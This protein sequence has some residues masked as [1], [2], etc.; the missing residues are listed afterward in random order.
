MKRMAVNPYL[1][2][3]EY[4]PDGEPHVFDGRL[5]IYGSHDKAHGTGYC[6]EDYVVWSAPVSDLSDWR[7]D[8]ISFRK[9]Q[10]SHNGCLKELWAPDV[11]KGTDGRYYLYYARAFVPEIGVAVSDSPAGPFEFYGFLQHENGEI[12]KE[13]LPFDPAVLYE[14]EDHIWLYSGFG[15]DPVPGMTMDMLQQMP[16]FSNLSKQELEG[17]MEHMDVMSNP[18]KSCSCLRLASDM[19]TVLKSSPVIPVHCN[20]AG[21]SFEEHPFLEASSIRKM[22]DTYYLVYSSIQGNEL[23]YATS[24]YPDRDFIFGGV[25]IS[26]GDLGYEGN[27]KRRAYTANNHGGMVEINGQWYIFY[28]RHTN[29][30][31]FSRQGCAEPITILSD[32]SIPQVEMTSCGLNGGALN[33]DQPYSAHICCNIMGADG[34][35]DID[36]YENMKMDNPYITE[37][38]TG[39]SKNQYVANLQ[40]GSVCGVKYLNFQGE[41]SVE[42][43]LRG[44]GQLALLLDH[45]DA[46]TFAAADVDSGEWKRYTM[47][48]EPVCGVHAIYFKCVS[49][50]GAVDFS[51]FC[52]KKEIDFKKKRLDCTKEAEHLVSLMSLEEKARMM[53]ATFDV[54]KSSPE[55]L[56][57][58]AEDTRNEEHHYN[59]FPY[60]AG[61]NERLNIPPML[62]VDGPRGVVCGNGKATCFPVSMCRGATFDVELEERIGKCIGKE[63]RAFGGNLFAGVCVNLPYH[64]GWGRSQ[65]TYGEESF[66]IGQM[67]AALVRGVQ[68]ED[69]MAC[70][71]HFA[72]NCME[73]ARF[74]CS[75]TCDQRT[76]KEVFLPHFKDCIDAGAASVM[77][78]YNRYNGVHCGHHSYLL[79]QVLKKEWDF[80]GF[81]MSDFLWGVK[82]TVEAA[83]GGQDMEMMMVQFFGD[84]LIKA[85]QDGFVPEE[86]VEDGALRIA[87][88]VMAF[89]K[90]HKEYDMSFAGCNEHIATAREVA[91]KGITLIKNEDVLPLQREKIKKLAVIGK[92]AAMETIGDH[93]SSQV[94]PAYVVTPLEG[95]R[96]LHKDCEVVFHDGA[97]I[98]SA[99]ELAANADAAIFVVGYDHDDEGEF[100]SEDQSENY[101][102]SVGGDRKNGLG[103]HEDEEKL[104]K[105]AG[106]LNPKSVAVLIGGNMIMMTEWYESVNAVVMAYY[107]GM[108]GG[109]ALAEILYGDVN[110]S[111]KLPFVV[112]REEKDLPFV[113]WEATDQYF[114][115]Y[116]G[117]TRL[118]KHGI[119]PFIPFGFGL[120]YTTFSFSGISA[121]IEGEELLT[122][123]EVANTGN[124]AGD[125]VVQVYAGYQN[126]AVD[127]PVKQLCGFA[128]VSLEAGERKSVKIQTPLEKLKW[129]NPVCRCWELERMEYQIYAGSSSSS[130]DL[131]QTT[132]QV[133]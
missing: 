123:V 71:K 61:G 119:Q 39:E 2:G 4:V 59:V 68:S 17:I 130:R 98:E 115:Y 10:D 62:F 64:P 112:P 45:E 38:E 47:T 74:K 29:L 58:M 23:C 108:E 103:L 104:L 80:D 24:K 57:K 21:T 76:E 14:D 69:I 32:G 87:R 88:T 16:E 5:Y 116:H 124:R 99:K 86:R 94:R 56:A 46:E 3:W 85:V 30:T 52:F 90:N 13:D 89:D 8:G 127:R 19:K 41:Q 9:E 65:E 43:V 126:S 7:C 128:R 44:K 132:I 92:L 100:I 83:N 114:E 55:S 133:I 122:M 93:G 53:S 49:E 11:C 35:K 113:D 110:P 81:V 1:P 105:E 79:N 91:E 25:I 70:V 121:C 106:P 6:Q 42:V 27:T 67:G 120:S 107:P 33:A 102:G 131:L 54:S 31:Q 72:F 37:E 82:D 26:N 84:K 97:D 75:V 78:A 109:T 60:G 20:A 118:E 15:T 125:E 129:Y 48:F 63:V 50:E 117:Y 111:G 22:K 28:H 95:I 36:H 51:E 96:R 18:S 40:T 77:S 66:Q 12:W 34:A 73:N 101:T